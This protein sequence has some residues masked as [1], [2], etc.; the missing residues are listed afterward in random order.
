[1]VWINSGPSIIR[2]RMAPPSSLFSGVFPLVLALKRLAE[3]QQDGERSERRGK[4]AID[5]QHVSVDV[6][7]GIRGQEYRGT[8]NFL[9]LAP[10][11][12]RDPALDEVLDLG[13]VDH[14][15]VGLGGEITGRNGI[16]GDALRPELDRKRPHEARKP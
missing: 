1:M 15:S 10:A 4:P 16:G 8:R 13:I 3:M 14:G 5:R 6:C 12:E 7:R 2:P 11:L 9:G